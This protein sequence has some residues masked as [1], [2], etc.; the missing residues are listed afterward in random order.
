MKASRLRQLT[1]ILPLPNSIM[2][3]IIKYTHI[4]YPE[5]PIVVPAK[6][7]FA[8]FEIQDAQNLFKA[9]SIFGVFMNLG[10]LEFSGST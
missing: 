5:I 10:K 6:G 8:N 2:S 7:G 9:I 1:Q 3:W 4:T